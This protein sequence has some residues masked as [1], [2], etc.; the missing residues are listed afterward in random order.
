[1]SFLKIM[2]GVSGTGKS[3]Y[4]ESIKGS[5]KK[6]ELLIISADDW[7]NSAAGYRFNPYHLIHAHNRCHIL[8]DT[9]INNED[10][11]MIIIDNTN[12]LLKDFQYYLETNREITIVDTTNRWLKNLSPEEVIELSLKRCA[13]PISI[14]S[15]NKQM[16]RY[17]SHNLMIRNYCKQINIIYED[18]L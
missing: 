6:E 18:L 2:R 4:I 5:F 14:E 7:F 15:L 9:Y 8:F 1:M 17:L 16:S 11:K 10:I 13:H 3:T 12:L